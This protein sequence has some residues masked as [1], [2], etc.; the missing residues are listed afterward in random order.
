MNR[1]LHIVSSPRGSA[2]Q[3][4][5]LAHT[6]IDAYREAHPGAEVNTF[7][8][9]DGTLPSFGPTAVAARAGVLAGRPLVGQQASVWQ[10]ITQTYARFAEHHGY[11]FSVPVWNGDVPYVLKQFIDVVSQ[12]RLLLDVHE[13]GVAPAPALTGKK[14]AVIYAS[15]GWGPGSVREDGTCLEKW[16]RWVGVRDIDAVFSHH[17]PA[18]E[19]TD[20]THRRAWNHARQAGLAF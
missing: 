9:W 7:D 14:A 6:F 8:L 19:E 13:E 12:P 4:L 17:H 10:S 11:L 20:L 1:L 2:S 16:L 18:A 5:T 15:D 3:S